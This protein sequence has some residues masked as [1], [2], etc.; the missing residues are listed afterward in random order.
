MLVGVTIPPTTPRTTEAGLDELALLVDTAGADEVGA[1]RAAARA[2]PTRPP[3]SARARPRSCARSRSSVDCDTVVFDNELT[4]GPAAQPREAARPHGHRPHRGDPRHLRPERPQPGGQGPGRAGPA[5]LPAAA[6]ARAGQGALSQ[7]RR[8]RHRHPWARA[9]P[10]SRSTAGASCA[11]STSSRP[12]SRDIAPHRDTQRKARGTRAGSHSVV[13]R[14]LHQRRQVDAAQPAHRRRRAGRGPAVR[15]P[16]RH[17]P[18]PR[19]CPAA[20]RCCSPTP[21]ASSASCPTSWSRRSSPR[22]RWSPRPTCWC[23]SSTARRPTPRRRS[24]PCATCSPRSAPARC[25]SCSCFNKAD[26]RPEAK[27]LV[28]RHP[29]SVGISALTGEG[30]DELLVADRRPAAGADRRG[31][32]ARALRPGRRAGRRP[33]RGRGAVRGATRPTACACGPGSTTPAP[34]RFAEFVVAS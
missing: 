6:P 27:R 9:R 16:R 18:P 7:Q 21:S 13:D 22:S 4:P 26:L 11:A 2:R 5:A 10:S 24:T 1:R 28:D 25:P 29:G 31:R 34:S 32:A 23:T 30:V 19:S 14:R 3:T 33:P 8:R 20:R 17:H 15:H 12:S